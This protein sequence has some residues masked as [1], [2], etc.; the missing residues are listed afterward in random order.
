MEDR[1]RP[2][3]LAYQMFARLD[4]R[5]VPI[6]TLWYFA[7]QDRFQINKTPDA[8]RLLLGRQKV[9]ILLRHDAYRATEQVNMNRIWGGD[10]VFLN[11]PVQYY[12][13]TPAR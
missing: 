10:H 6:G 2:L 3:D 9:S 7:D 1:V 11:I 13:T 8:W 12:N 5:E 4:G